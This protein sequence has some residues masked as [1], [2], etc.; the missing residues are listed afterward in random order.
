MTTVITCVLLA[1]LTLLVGAQGEGITS[2]SILVQN[3]STSPATVHVDFYNTTGTNT[4]FKEIA[5]LGGEQTTTFDQR[6]SSGD[7][8]TDP[9]Q[10]A[11][12]L[13][14]D[15]PIGAVV[16]VVRTSGSGGVNSY[17]AYNGVG[18]AAGTIQAPLILR[19]INSAGKVWNTTMAIQNISTS[20]TASVQVDFTPAGIGT[21]DTENYTIPAGG[22]WYLAQKDQT[23]LGTSFFGSAIISAG[24]GEEVAVVVT[25]GTSDG[26]LLIVY[27]S[28]ASGST[29][30]YLPGAMK[31]ILSMG[32]NYFTSMTIVNMGGSGDPDP[33]VS[34]EYQAQTGTSSGPY[35]VTVAN[36]TTIDM[37]TDSAI[38]SGSF[39]GAVKLTSTNGTPIAAML[40][41]RG[42][43]AVS[44]A[45]K[46]AS[47]YGGISSGVTTAFVPYLLKYIN[48]A[49]YSWSTTILLQNLDPGAGD[50]D[51][52]VT[53]NEDPLFGTNSYTSLQTGIA[54][55]AFVDLRY[56]PN[57][58]GAGFYGGAKIESTNGRPF[59][60]VVLVRGSS[61]A[62]DAL[63]SYLGVS[64]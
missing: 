58:T 8:G 43:N 32:D 38:T 30:V 41:T 7:P 12:I 56:D 22:T 60:V 10:G 49:G 57:I 15:Q 36:A 3:L 33:I 20:S 19:G 28:Y 23:G 53:Y 17:E 14:A 31:N 62:G 40:N 1:S 50:L 39:M 64:P 6:Y 13:S 9:F 4:G 18:T 44:G 5:S 25:S 55:F 45:A 47:T 24:A 48:S 52:S 2:T 27:P 29:N 59:G 26:S 21:A 34:V 63:S 11:A 46:Y 42:D 37:R 51:V 61:G 16:Q 35:N 54:D